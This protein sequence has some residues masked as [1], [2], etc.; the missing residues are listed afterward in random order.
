[1]NMNKTIAKILAIFFSIIYLL[2]FLLFFYGALICSFEIEPHTLSD[3][4]FVFTWFL[5]P[6]SFLFSI[7][8]MWSNYIKSRYKG[9]MQC[10]AI[11]FLA[12]LIFI[13]INT[14]FQRS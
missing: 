4:I 2:L 3:F 13:A 11:P 8:L 12:F 5:L 1:M 7:Y 14:V 9:S 10:C 6:F